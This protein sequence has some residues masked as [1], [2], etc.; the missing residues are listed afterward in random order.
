MSTDEAVFAALSSSGLKGTKHAWPEGGPEGGVPP[1]PWFTYDLEDD[2]LLAAD[3]SNYN[4]LPTYRASLY[5]ESTGGD[6][7]EAFEDA[8]ASLGPHSREE[9]WLAS[10]GCWM[11]TYTFTYTGGTDASF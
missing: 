7:E 1:L 6:A 5:E 4:N 11:V 3:D 2:G 8:V 9:Y 10:E